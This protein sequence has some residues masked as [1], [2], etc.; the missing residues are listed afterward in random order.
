MGFAGLPEFH[1]SPIP[2]CRYAIDFTG[3]ADTDDASH[4]RMLW[5]APP[6]SPF[7]TLVTITSHHIK[8]IQY[9]YGLHTEPASRIY[10]DLPTRPRK[11]G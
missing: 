3:T 2:Y 6:Y 5:H 7:L 11:L 1:I 4:D 10:N 9:H 8:Q